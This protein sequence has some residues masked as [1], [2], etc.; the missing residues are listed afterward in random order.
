MPLGSIFAT[1][2]AYVV[3]A[4]LLLSLNLT[5]RWRWWIKGGAIV[6]TGLFFIGSYL[7]ITSLLGW[8]TEA[9]VPDHFSLVATR[10]VEPDKF[11][12]APGAI[13]LWVEKLDENNVPNG[14]PRG[15]QLGYTEELA[16]TVDEVQALIDAGEPV[17][18]NIDRNQ[19]QDEGDNAREP[20]QGEGGEARDRN[21]YP[22]V[23]FNITFNDLPAV[24]L[25]DKGVL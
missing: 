11:T 5:S 20:G 12:G 10:V 21:A 9:R 14:V 6:V 15:Y 25:P 22:A 24:R 18:G 7:A 3:I 4:V 8:P 17:E 2:V 13:F 19:P 1:V 23:E 16:A